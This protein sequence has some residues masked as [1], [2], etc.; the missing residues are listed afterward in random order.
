MNIKDQ[1]DWLRIAEVV[2]RE[3]GEYLRQGLTR[4]RQI[5]FEDETDVKL[6]ADVDSEKL[7]R[8]VLGEKTGLPVI[9]EEEGGDPSLLEGEEY[10]WVVDPLDGTYNYLR[11]QPQTCVSI[12][13]MKGFEFVGGV[14]YDFN[15][16]ELYSGL[17]G[18]RLRI[19]NEL[20]EPSWV[21]RVVE[22]CLMTGFP[23]RQDCTPDFLKGF[24]DYVH[25]FKKVR[26]VGSAAIALATV[27]AGRADVY[28]ENSICLWD[29]AA[30]AAL[31]K[32]AGGYI[33]FKP[34]GDDPFVIDFWAAGRKEFIEY[35]S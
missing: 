7:I 31:V 16:D 5:N 22:G 21:T 12:G 34:A 28:F 17:V 1:G 6:Q 35:L 13:L 19:N 2:S 10:F 23:I 18:E 9:G 14:I 29:I 11:N 25:R 8:R 30:G 15:R 4:S 3:A 20:I 27:A 24:V 32:A 33:K 26:M